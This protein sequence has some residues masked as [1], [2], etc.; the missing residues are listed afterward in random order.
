MP[1]VVLASSTYHELERGKGSKGSTVQRFPRATH[2]DILNSSQNDD[3]TN[4]AEL[5]NLL[6]NRNSQVTGR[7]NF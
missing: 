3:P 6:S 5:T 4:N 2:T 7:N 1:S